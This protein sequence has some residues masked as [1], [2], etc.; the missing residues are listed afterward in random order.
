V[1][2]D[3]YHPGCRRIL[4]QMTY[5]VYMAICKTTGGRYIGITSKGLARRRIEHVTKRS[6][7]KRI[8]PAFHAAIDK[9]GKDDFEWVCLI[10][11]LDADEA[12][13]L[14]R[15]LISTMKP[16]YNVAAGG[17]SGSG[18]AGWKRSPETKARMSASAK[19]R[20]MSPTTMA[21]RREA[22]RQHVTCIET[23]TVFRDGAEAAM[24]HGIKRNRVYECVR[25]KNINKASGASFRRSTSQEIEEYKVMEG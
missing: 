3:L 15:F 19:A 17:L 20:G 14:E 16:R 4:P 10:D 6:A 8:C 7:G 1:G 25:N 12:A 9:Y 11:G 18:F 2:L 13:H 21:A 23:G 22:L 24:A 5:T